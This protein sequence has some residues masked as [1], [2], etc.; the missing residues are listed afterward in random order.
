[1]GPGNDECL[2]SVIQSCRAFKVVHIKF[3]FKWTY[4]QISPNSVLT[5]LPNI[6]G[7]LGRPGFDPRVGRIPWRRTWQPTPVFLPGESPW[8]KKPGRLWSM[9]SQEVRHDWVTKHTQTPNI[10]VAKPPHF[11]PS[12]KELHHFC[13]HR[14]FCV[15][16]RQKAVS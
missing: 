13:E 10:S 11:P 3:F 9:G 16:A 6:L 4:L 2:S 5:I 15:R 14:P 8:T 12:P 7:F 1:M